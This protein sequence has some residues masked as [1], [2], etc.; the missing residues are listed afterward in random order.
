MHAIFFYNTEHRFGRQQTCE[1]AV[2]VG[3]SLKQ[4]WGLRT[5]GKKSVH[6]SEMQ[7]FLF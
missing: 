6:Q 1:N 2:W 4:R 7:Q 3:I 5:C